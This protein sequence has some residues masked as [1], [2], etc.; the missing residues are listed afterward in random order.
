ML[1]LPAG[2]IFVEGFSDQVRHRLAGA[3][4]LQPQASQVLWQDARA[5]VPY[6]LDIVLRYAERGGLGLSNHNSF[7]T[8]VWGDPARQRCHRQRRQLFSAV[9]LHK[10]HAC[11]ERGYRPG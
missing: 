2:K 7:Y 1:S 11:T 10:P 5:V 9:R 6:P 3:L 8:P 4:L